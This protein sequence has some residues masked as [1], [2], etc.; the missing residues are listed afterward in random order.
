MASWSAHKMQ[1]ALTKKGFRMEQG[2]HRM[3]W[4]HVA[5]RKTSV[6]T[7][8]SHGAKEYG[9]PLLARMADQLGLDRAELDRL[10]ACPLSA[11]EYLRLLREREVL[12]D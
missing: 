11:D 4:L 8:I 7:R 12:K 6:R 9:E 2:H 1:N 10:F 3:F 5:G